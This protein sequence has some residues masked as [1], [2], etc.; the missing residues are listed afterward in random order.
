MFSTIRKANGGGWR[1]G[2]A[3]ASYLANPY[4][5]LILRA[6]WDNA[7]HRGM[8]RQLNQWNKRGF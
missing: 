7:W 4:R 3:G 1:A 8:T 2:M 5:N 6:V